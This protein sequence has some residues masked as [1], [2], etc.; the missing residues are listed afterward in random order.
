[1]GLSYLVGKIPT[2]YTHPQEPA[3][4][5]KSG[6]SDVSV[7]GRFLLIVPP[8]TV[9]IGSSRHPDVLCGSRDYVSVSNQRIV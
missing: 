5:Y 4:M 1:M 3:W 2:P 8:E 9:R 6:S 7:R